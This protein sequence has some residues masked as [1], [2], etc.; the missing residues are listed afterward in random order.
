MSLRKICSG[1]ALI[2][3]VAPLQF[4]GR[5]FAVERAF[6]V[7][8]VPSWV[9]QAEL[10]PPPDVAIGDVPKGAHTLL[11]DRQIRVT[12]TDTHRYYRRVEHILS[13]TGL[14]AVSQ[15]QLDFEPSY[16][17]L[18]IHF[19]RIHR[20]G[21]IIDQLHPADI[22]VIQ[23]ESEL[24]ERLYNGTLSAV[25]FLDDVRVGD[26]VDY[27][28]SIDGA[29]P[30]LDGKFADSFYLAEDDPVHRLR[31]RLMWPEGRPLHRS[32]QRSDVEPVVTQLG[33]ESELVWDLQDVPSVIFDDDTPEWFDPIPRVQLSEFGT[34]GDV[35]K[36]A[37]PLFRVDEPLS[38]SL[39]R[40][41]ESWKAASSDPARR[42]VE[43]TRF[44]QDDVR[45]LGIELG[46]YSH[47]PNEPSTVYERRFGDCK[48]KALLLV[49]ILTAL[50]IEAYPAL[51]NTESQQALDVWQ[52][53]PFAFNH[54]IAQVILEGETYWID[55]T[56]SLQRGGL[57][58]Y[59]NPS[60]ARALVVRSDTRELTT[61]PPPTSDRPTIE[62][63][64]LYALDGDGPS[65]VLDVVTTYRGPEADEVRYRLT[66]HSRAE[67][68]R[69]FLNYYA[70]TDPSIE[71]DGLP[72]IEDDPA[73]NTVV[74]AEKYTIPRF[75]DGGEREIFADRIENELDEPRIS[76]RTMPL[77]VSFPV[78]VA[79]HIEVRLGR[80]PGVGED[81]GTI[82]G[83]AL[84]FDYK[85]A[86][87]GG[88]LVLDYTLRTLRDN[89]EPD[90]VK[91]HLQTLAKIRKNLEFRLDEE[92]TRITMGTW[93]WLSIMLLVVIG[94]LT[95]GLMRMRG[96]RTDD[97]L[98]APTQG[99]RA[100]RLEPGLG[101]ETALAVPVGDLGQHVSN[102]MC[103]CGS[104][105]R[106]DA[107]GADR[108]T[109]TFDGKKMLVVGLA[110]SSC[111]LSRDLY[112][113][114][115]P[116]SA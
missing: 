14:D 15:L 56:I 106:S 22:K 35:I 36:W 10:G 23:Q 32:T 25:V 58:Q 95:I 73:T 71:A 6:A 30:V 70:L 45:Y 69:F 89:V 81:S 108:Q 98:E 100:I 64:S 2:A 8:A 51:V 54:C 84:R 115:G 17:H 37:S 44:V 91:A 50:G 65:A 26:I 20:D 41:I 96:Q 11:L 18:T 77:A 55:A 1:L 31:F 63:T 52:P 61:I 74:I 33:G 12:A 13:A 47:L 88:A 4:G 78:H 103:T 43:A 21:K 66:Q 107:V 3:A 27:A 85:Y 79:Q 34:W 75:W 111:G 53:S 87:D 112:F 57:E 104:R 109:L 28:F 82:E 105:Y 9:A 42:L 90:Q 62:V 5:A 94:P 67:V 80:D 19:I 68:G 7:G 48:D 99:P 24:D 97:P 93:V 29:N 83:G 110:C 116:G 86:V 16:E 59:Y 60:Y 39:T 40:Q 38:P 92:P 76:R 102:L 101:P 46:P 114:N 113:V 72:S 49:T